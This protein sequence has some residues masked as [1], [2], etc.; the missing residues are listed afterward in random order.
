MLEALKGGHCPLQPTRCR[1]AAFSVS[2]KEHIV[3]KLKVLLIGSDGRTSALG[4][5]LAKSKSV[6]ELYCAPGNPQLTELGRC[7]P[8]QPE[9]IRALLVHARDIKPDLVVCGPEG[10]LAAGLVDAFE[11]AGFVCSD[12]NA[13]AMRLEADKVFCCELLRKHKIPQPHFRVASTF[14]RAA[15]LVRKMEPPIVIK[16]QGLCGGKGVF[17]AENDVAALPI[18]D[19]LLRQRERGKA[20]ETVVLQEHLYGSEASFFVA[21]DGTEKGLGHAMDYKRLSAAPGA[22][23]TGG[24]GSISPH[25][26]ITP[27]LEKEILRTIVYPTTRAMSEEGRPFRGI[28]YFGLMLTHGGKKLIPKVLEINARLGHPEAQALLPRFLNDAGGTTVDFGELFLA[29]AKEQ[30]CLFGP[31]HGLTERHDEEKVH[32]A[33]VV[34][35]SQGYPGKDLLLEQE[36]CDIWRAEETGALVFHDGTAKRGDKLVNVKGRVL[37]VVGRGATREAAVAQAYE[38]AEKITFDG[39]FYRKDIGTVS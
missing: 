9:D 28:L 27:E 38:A 15:E 37:N 1:P 10:P 16:A 33:C 7:I 31:V 6:T 22:P 39:M 2:A 23:N 32:T 4:F 34:L 21:T 36:I 24:M 12:P 30:L 17:I 8:V 18:L 20:A 13:A 5:M 14:G 19:R 29:I 26:L 3:K 11:A 25:P 35:A